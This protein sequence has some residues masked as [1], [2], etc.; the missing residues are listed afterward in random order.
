MTRFYYVL[1]G[2]PES[3]RRQSGKESTV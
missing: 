2:T 1:V 3:S